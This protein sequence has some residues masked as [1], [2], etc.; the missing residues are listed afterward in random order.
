MNEFLSFPKSHDPGGRVRLGLPAD[1]VSS[2][3]FSPCGQ[4]R[5][6]L[7]RTWNRD[8]PSVLFIG[9][10]PSTADAEVDDPTVRKECGFARDHGFG[11]LHK[12]NVM[13]YR[14]TNP[15]SLLKTG[16]VPASVSNLPTIAHQLTLVSTVVCVWGRLH[17]ALTPHAEAVKHLIRQNGMAVV[18]L[19]TNIDGS[20]KHPLYLKSTTKFQPFDL[21]NTYAS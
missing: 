11:S 16:V 19:G 21:G 20:P 2:A 9:M 3:T 1:V 15:K 12:C 18:C 6:L 7:T 4:Y 13:D 8:L 14:A 17:P 10:N 5:Q